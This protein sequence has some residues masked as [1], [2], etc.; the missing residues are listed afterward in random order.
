MFALHHGLA[1]NKKYLN[2]K[3]RFIS[4]T[5]PRQEGVDTPIAFLSAIGRKMETYAS[6]FE[7]WNHLFTSTSKQL[8]TLGLNAKA[9]KYLLSWRHR[10]IQ[11][12]TLQTVHVP[13][14]NRLEKQKPKRQE[15]LDSWREHLAFYRKKRLLKRQEARAKREVR[16]RIERSN[17]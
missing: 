7:S 16:K 5:N 14:R 6:K 3:V 10:Y 2:Q 1:R 8:E 17:I 11:G 9:R 12:H 13:I 4:S 15:R